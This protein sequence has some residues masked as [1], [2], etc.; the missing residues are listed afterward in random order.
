MLIMLYAGIAWARVE[1]VRRSG[2]MSQAQRHMIPILGLLTEKIS[3]GQGFFQGAVCSSSLRVQL[4]L[5]SLQLVC[6]YGRVSF[7]EL[8][9]LL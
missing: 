8:R 4:S 9:V 5:Q 7:K 2:S 1:S 3:K 6:L